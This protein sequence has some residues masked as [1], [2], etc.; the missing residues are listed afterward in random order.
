MNLEAY[1]KII[2]ECRNISIKKNN[3]YGGTIDNIS[4]AGPHGIAVRLLDK[5]SRLHCLTTPGKERKVQDE[6]IR[7][8]CKDMI[9]YA[10]YCIMLLDGT[11]KKEN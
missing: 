2:G 11:W 10:A 3:D 8:T 6:S 4:L 9:N 5:V 1:D 7:D